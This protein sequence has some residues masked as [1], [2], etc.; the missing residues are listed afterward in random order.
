M[1]HVRSTDR[2]AVCEVARLTYADTYEEGWFE[3]MLQRIR[4]RPWERA[5]WVG[6]IGGEVVGIG[7]A[8]HYRGDREQPVHP[9]P[10]GWYL[11]GRG[12]SPDYRR[13]G[14]A[15]ALTQARLDWMR[16]RGA[17]SAYYFQDADNA[18]SLRA[19]ESFGFRRRE[20]RVIFPGTDRTWDPLLHA[21]LES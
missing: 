13:L 7:L 2:E 19:H 15:T 16:S 20:G 11:L 3:L 17:T 8:C 9:A 10:A 6:S 5:M 1:R 12:V 14:V 4:E 18:A 21:P